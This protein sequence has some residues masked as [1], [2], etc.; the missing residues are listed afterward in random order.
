MKKFVV[1]IVVCSAI[2][3]A[4]VSLHRKYKKQETAYKIAVSNLKSYDDLLS[5]SKEK[6][7][8]LQ[9]T[10]DQLIYVKDSL[11]KNLNEVRKQ[12][13][14]KD[15]NLKAMQHVSTILVRNDTIVL[16]DTV[17][18]EPAFA[19]DTIIGDTWCSTHLTFSYPSQITL[20]PSFKS[21]KN[22]IVSSR[23]ET[24]NPPKKW[25]IFRLFQKKH[26]VIEVNVLESNPYVNKQESRYVEILK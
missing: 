23:K 21:E 8:A 25:W 22:I 10:T 24:I 20:T 26:Q 6:N 5:S 18:R 12:L 9:L 13:G 3:V 16:Q 2:V 11:I 14:I 4:F 1:F 19:L 15:K 17:F 7:R